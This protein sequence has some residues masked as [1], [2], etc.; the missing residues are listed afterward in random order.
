VTESID[1]K[2][3][4][5]VGMPSDPQ[6]LSLKKYTLGDVNDDGKINVRDA[7]LVVNKIIGK[8]TQ[9]AIEEAMDMN[10]DGK[11]NVRD[12]ILIVNIII[13]KE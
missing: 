6:L 7:M 2:S 5:Q 9:N 8:D 11:I 13:G 4:V 12:A 3:D 1:F 10:G